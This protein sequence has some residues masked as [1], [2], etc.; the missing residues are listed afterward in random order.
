M[1]RDHI[2][3][4]NPVHRDYKN[5]EQGKQVW[6]DID[7]KIRPPTGNFSSPVSV[8]VMGC[9]QLAPMGCNSGRNNASYLYVP[10][11]IYLLLKNSTSFRLS[12]NDR[13]VLVYSPHVTR[14]SKC[15]LHHILRFFFVSFS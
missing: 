12:K 15:S 10:C 13:N 1:V 11:V 3:L 2:L 4:W 8:S 9:L 6:E 5:K 7:T 14:S